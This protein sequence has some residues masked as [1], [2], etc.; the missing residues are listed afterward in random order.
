MTIRSK[1]DIFKPKIY[2]AV[3]TYEEQNNFDQAINNKNWKKDMDEECDA[4]MRNKT[5]NLVHPLE[6]NI[7]GCKRTFRLKKNPNGTIA[8]YKAGL[9]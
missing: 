7:M 3:I 2:T 1:S 5:S 8:R 9:G 4:L 6:K